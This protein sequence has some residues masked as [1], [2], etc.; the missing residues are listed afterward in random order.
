MAVSSTDTYSGPYEANGVTVAFPFTF[1]AVAA[2]DVA[3]FIRSVDGSDTIVGDNAYAVALASEGGTVTFGTP[4]AS[5]QVYIVSEPSFL[6]AI[7]FASGQAFLPNVVNEVNDRDVVRA[8]YLK[9]AL[10]RAPKIPIGGGFENLFPISLPGGIWGFSVGTGADAGLRTD[11]AESVSG[12]GAGMSAFAPAVAYGAGTVGKKLQQFVN[13]QDFGAV[14]NGVTDDYAAFSAAYDA[15]A[16]GGSIYVPQVGSE[17]Y[18]L[19]DNPDAGDKPVH[20]IFD[21]AIQFHGPG[22]GDPDAGAGTFASLYTNPWLRVIGGQRKIAFGTVNSPAGGAVVGDSWEWTADSLAGW[23]KAITGNLTN[24][25][26]VIANVPAGVIGSLYKGCRITSAVS[27]WGYDGATT[28]NLRI[29]S[30]DAD[31]NTVTVG[32]DANGNWVN[33][34]APYLGATAS[35]VSF[36]VHKRQWFAGRYEGLETG[37]ED[38]SIAGE[39]HYEICN[40]VMNITGAAGAMYEFNLNSYAETLD[41]CRA[42]FITGSGDVQNGKLVAID[43]QRGGE[44]HWATG[45]SIRNAQVGLFTNAKF[46]IEI[47]TVYN[48]N[49]TGLTETIGYGVH[50]NNA[51]AVKGA[52]FEG[53]QLANALP[54]LTLW[55]YT[56][57]SPTGRFIQCK[58][59]AD[60]NE[61][62]YVGIDGG[63]KTYAP[64]NS[65]GSAVAAGSIECNGIT[66]RGGTNLQLGQV[67]AT[68]TKAANGKYLTFYDSAGAAV[69]VPTYA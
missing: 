3:V 33:T 47:D 60:A 32:Y 69:Y 54:A 52:L 29:L 38:A 16:W 6:Q 28:R 2:D 5:G 42:I 61:L 53:R 15:V 18:Y 9:S 45:I 39:V 63:L 50:F 1:K 65:N 11:L 49:T 66:L 59:A 46:P 31:A 24:G 25:S 10:D 44:A 36:T 17:G 68:A 12:K 22:L 26:A 19:S 34:P 20:W 4:P 55:R 58:D 57:S 48:N 51:P 40:P 7:S 56:D 64:S 41:Y 14:G 37:T 21:T 23:P 35:G 30:V 8:L 13:V 43:I 27:Q 62:F 67:A